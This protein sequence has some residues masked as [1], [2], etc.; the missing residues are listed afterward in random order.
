MEVNASGAEMGHAQ[1]AT[2]IGVNQKLCLK[3]ISPGFGEM[4]PL[5]YKLKFVWK[6]GK[7]MFYEYA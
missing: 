4:Q 3:R 7:V 1:V 2:K 5:E 6:V